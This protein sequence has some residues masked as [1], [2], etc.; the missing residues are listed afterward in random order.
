[1][2]DSPDC[3][4]TFDPW[5]GVSGHI[6]LLLCY[7]VAIIIHII[8]IYVT[9][10]SMKKNSNFTNKLFIMYLAGNI[11]LLLNYNVASCRFLTLTEPSKPCIERKLSY[12][13]NQ[14]GTIISIVALNV[15]TTTHFKQLR[16]VAVINTVE[17]KKK[18]H[19][20]SLIQ[21]GL[22]FSISIIFIT[23]PVVLDLKQMIAIIVWY[24]IILNFVS[25]YYCYRS[26]RLPCWSMNA[27]MAYLMSIKSNEMLILATTCLAVCPQILNMVIHIIIYRLNL[28]DLSRIILMWISRLNIIGLILKALV[29]LWLHPYRKRRKTS[30]I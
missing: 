8:A 14:L 22:L 9:V 27:N 25:V 16:S 18:L 26:Y 2:E 29:Y 30:F 5:Q 6:V 28:T 13:S 19:H 4:I 21:G 3:I 11:I 20:F 15:I 10:L 23:L 24:Q 17:D 7:N 1:M 12:L